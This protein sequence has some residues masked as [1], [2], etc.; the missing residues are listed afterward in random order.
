MPLCPIGVFMYLPV[1]VCVCLCLCADVGSD[2]E[3]AVFV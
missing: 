3:V 1:Y 2:E